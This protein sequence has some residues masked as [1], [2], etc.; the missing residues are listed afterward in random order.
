MTIAMKIVKFMLKIARLTLFAFPMLF[1]GAI[2]LP[3]TIFGWQGWFILC[4]MYFEGCSPS[5]AKRLIKEEVYKFGSVDYGGYYRNPASISSFDYEH[6]NSP[7][8]KHL[9]FNIHHRN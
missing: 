8:Y 2:T 4:T 3:L 6:V 1:L 7:A 5:E 9:P